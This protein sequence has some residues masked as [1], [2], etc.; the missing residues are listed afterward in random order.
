MKKFTLCI[1][2]LFAIVSLQAQDYHISFVG[3]GES[4][5]VGTVMVEN[6]TQGKSLILNGTE[7]LHLAK[8]ITGLNPIL[9]QE[10]ALQI[11]PNPATDNSIIEFVA[12]ASGKVNVEIFDITGKILGAAQNTLAIGT[13]SY[14]ISNF[15]SGIYSVRISS[16]A[17]TYDGKLVGNGT[18]NLDVKISYIGCG[19]LPITAK[20]LKSASDEKVMQYNIGDRLKITGESGIYSTVIVDVPTQNKTITFN[21]VA[22]TDADGNNYPVVQIGNQ[23]WM[24]E[25]LNTTK[26]FNGDPIQNISDDGIWTVL[27]TGAYCNYN[28]DI[29]FA[30]TYNHL[31]NF[32]ALSDSRKIIPVG[33]H[34]PTDTEWEILTANLGGQLEAGSKLKE[35]GTSHWNTPNIDA[36]NET[37]F[38]ATPG[39][40]RRSGIFG[41]IGLYGGWWSSTEFNPTSVW[42]R[43]LYYNY[44][45]IGRN[46]CNKTYGF[47]V[48]CVYDE[49]VLI[50]TTP[51][52]N[53]K[54]ANNITTSSANSGGNI[55]NDGGATITDR[56]ICWNTTGTPTIENSITT[57]SS[58]SVN[59]TS[60]LSGLTANT[61]YYV[62]AYATNIKGTAYGSEKKFKTTI[63]G[64]PNIVVDSDNNVYH[65]VTIGTQVWMVEN[66]KST[67]YN[68]GTAIP[69]VTY[70]NAWAN[71]TTPAY[72]WYDNN[73][74][75]K[76][77]YGALYNWYTINTGKL[78]PTGWHVPSDEEWST[79]TA[80]L[81]GEYEAGSKLKETGTTHWSSFNT[82]S[83]N[84]TG[85][86][87]LPGGSRGGSGQIGSDGTF[88]NIGTFGNWW[89]SSKIS[90]GSSMYRFM[91]NIYSWVYRLHQ[92]PMIG[93]SVRCIKD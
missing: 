20:I 45:N 17:Y 1:S 34:L 80:F 90:E 61:N 59:F 29:N 66:L 8:T 76:N 91:D 75:N 3:S 88:I 37:G 93:L 14:K 49:L 40:A 62:R 35:N 64:E 23:I 12:T 65:T 81:G 74:I 44:P 25:N 54:E 19:S 28:N 56:G 50:I 38:T 82:L 42:L 48:R 83:T 72:C 57:N 87:A 53:T 84:E 55:I 21:F 67:K 47:S 46:Y 52:L 16:Q 41:N 58:G 73:T 6:M 69:N 9:D 31:Y 86:T 89:S 10:K 60:E 13:H 11:Y 77:T 2:I 68:D 7:V 18:S 15:Q 51:T 78:A 43:Y 30:T 36:T 26:Y 39:G 27:T 79:L 71:L 5:Q 33:W 70:D 24:A 85:F 32:Y 4:T 63:S 92:R 22:C